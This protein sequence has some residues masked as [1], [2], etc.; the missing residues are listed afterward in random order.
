MPMIQMLKTFA[1]AEHVLE[2]GKVYTLSDKFV[3]ELIADGACIPF[4]E[5]QLPKDKKSRNR[6]MPDSR[7]DPQF[8]S[9]PSDVK[10]PVVEVDED[11][12]DE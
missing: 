4:K 5:S 2:T 3:A 7:P 6:M 11:E 8:G 1:S 12:D 10:K 9:K